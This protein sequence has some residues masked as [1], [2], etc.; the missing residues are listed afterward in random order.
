MIYCQHGLH[1]LDIGFYYGKERA[2]IV[3]AD[4]TQPIT[5]LLHSY[6]VKQSLQETLISINDIA[7]NTNR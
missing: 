4:I 5:V 3:K 7:Y 1:P 2:I 6:I